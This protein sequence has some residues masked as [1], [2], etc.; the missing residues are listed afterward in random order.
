MSHNFAKSMF[1]AA[2]LLAGPAV[3][4][5]A[6]QAEVP[7]VPTTHYGRCSGNA[8]FSSAYCE[9]LRAAFQARMR[10]CMAQ[11]QASSQ[12]YRSKF[13]LCNAEVSQALGRFGD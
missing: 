10:D 8:E 1:L 5:T 4:D 9:N 12:G 13:L 3:A 2:I 7:D 11:S 6:P